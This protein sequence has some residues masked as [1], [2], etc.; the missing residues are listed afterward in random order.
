V[1]DTSAVR[2]YNRWARLYDLVATAPGVRSWRERA[3]EALG[4]DPGDTVVEMGCGTGAN[5]PHLRERIGAGGRVLG[6]D[7]APGMLGR[8]SERVHRADWTNVTLL[9]GDATAPPID[10]GV[11]AILAT[12]VVG[13]LEDP[14]TTVDEWLVHLVPGGRLVLLNAGRSRHP[15]AAPLNLLFRAFVRLN[16][17]GARTVRESPARALERKW[18]AARDTLA[19]RSVSVVE[20]RLGLGYVTLAGGRLPDGRR[21]SA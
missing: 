16:A 12:F 18:D 21:S 8:A 20:E 5:L 13:M 9:V 1:S 4:L 2:F 14:A 10:G 6:L 15:L 3:T 19:E 7:F 11:D 17:A